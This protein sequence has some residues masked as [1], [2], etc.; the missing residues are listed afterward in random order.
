M[1][2]ELVSFWKGKLIFR[3]TRSDAWDLIYFG[4]GKRDWQTRKSEVGSRINRV[5]TRYETCRG[6]GTQVRR[7]VS[8]AHFSLLEFISNNYF[9]YS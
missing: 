5:P 7:K 3:I 4:V 6:R 2:F 1:D 8:I 9:S